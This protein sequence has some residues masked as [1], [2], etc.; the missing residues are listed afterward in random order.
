MLVIPMFLMFVGGLGAIY[1]AEDSKTIEYHCTGSAA[2]LLDI[3]IPMDVAIIAEVPDS[4]AAGED[5]TI[6]N[7]YTNI[8]MEATDILKTAANPLEG[9]VTEFNLELNN[10]TARDTGEDF[11][12]VDDEA[13]SFG[14]IYISE[15]DEFVVYRVSEV[16]IILVDITD[17]EL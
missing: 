11:V 16:V 3:D 17:G 10:A 15:D 1:A 12:N 8:S 13:L 5:F 7:S 14:P 9:E 4:V 6:E 2:G